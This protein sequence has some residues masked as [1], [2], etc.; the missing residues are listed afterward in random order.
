[1]SIYSIFL[2][3]ILVVAI[4][5]GLYGIYQHYWGLD[6]TREMI[7]M[8]GSGRF[9]A[10]FLARLGTDKVFSTFVFP[11]ALAGYLILI[12]PLALALFVF[13]GSGWQRILP[14]LTLI[15]GGGSLY[16]TYSKGG[17]LS[18]VLS[19]GILVFILTRKRR[20]LFFIPFLVVAGLFLFLV[21]SGIFPNINLAGFA[22]SFR[23]RIDYWKSGMEMLKDYFLPGSGLGTFG[24]LY[25]KYK[26]P[27]A[28]ET[29]LAHNN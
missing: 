22:E 23:V 17:W 20:R 11:P 1:M 10:N 5:V 27:G 9:S 2:P 29:Q 19:L 13:A 26:L 24:S 15:V 21:L 3:L 14:G 25:A 18:F 28:G 7:R 4:L 16:F 12:L 8:H 6:Q